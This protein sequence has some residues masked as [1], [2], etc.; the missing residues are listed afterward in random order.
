MISTLQR[1]TTNTG[2]TTVKKKKQTKNKSPISTLSFVM[3]CYL[4]TPSQVIK[5]KLSFTRHF[6]EIFEQNINGDMRY[7][8][9]ENDRGRGLF[10]LV[11]GQVRCSSNQE[12]FYLLSTEAELH[13]WINESFSL[14][15]FFL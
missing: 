14:V 10:F 11:F 13:V 15:F 2:L 7:N 4:L 3:R 12:R 6:H 5:N 1:S 8:F 9:T